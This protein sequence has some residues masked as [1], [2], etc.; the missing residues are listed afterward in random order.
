MC[1]RLTAGLARCVAMSDEQKKEKKK[2]LLD[3]LVEAPDKAER[4][5]SLGRGIQQSAQLAREVAG[6]MREIVSEVPAESVPLEEWTHQVSVWSSW[7]DAANKLEGS[8]TLANTFSAMSSGVFSTSA[9]AVSVIGPFMLAQGPQTEPAKSQ[10]NRVLARAPLAEDAQSAMRR[11]KLDR[12]AGDNRTPMELLEEARTAFGS[13]PASAL[14][15]LREC[16]QAAIADLLRRRATQE[17]AGKFSE[18]MASLAGQCARDG[19][20]DVHFEGLAIDGKRLLDTLSGAKQA[21][22]SPEKVSELFYQGLAF[23][24]A[25]LDSIDETRLKP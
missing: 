15:P 4:L 19:L 21:G 2:E 23:L 8:I 17:P 25:L 18:K 13:G 3:L 11:L 1:N 12:R 20:T 16:I 5:R 10:L 9:S 7:H 24:N 14:L 22:M 6:P